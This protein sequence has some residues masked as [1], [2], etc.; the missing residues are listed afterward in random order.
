MLPYNA[1]NTPFL[2]ELPKLYL[3]G[4]QSGEAMLAVW[5]QNCDGI[6]SDLIE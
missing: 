1:K 3:W 2:S 5:D 4:Y 6:P